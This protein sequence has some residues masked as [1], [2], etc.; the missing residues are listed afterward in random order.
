[1]QALGNMR[2]S[3]TTRVLIVIL[4]LG[5][6]MFGFG[7]DKNIIKVHFIESGKPEPFAVSDMPLEQLPDTFEIDTTMHL[8]DDD[9]Q[10]M[11]AEPAQ[12]EVF[13]KK[14]SLKLFLKK[15]EIVSIDPKDILYSLPTI[16]NDLA[17]VEDSET[18]ENIIVFREDDWRQF[19][20]LSIKYEQEIQKELRG[21]AEIYENQKLEGVGFKEIYL[22]KIIT[23]PLHDINLK[24]E[25]LEKYFDIKHQYSGVAFNNA[26]ATIVGGFAFSTTSGWELWGQVNANNIIQFINITQT[27]DSDVN[28]F[29]TKIDI[30][31]TENKMYAV[32]WARMFWAGHNK[33]A[34]SKYTK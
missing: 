33:H 16:S 25:V 6:P 23:T 22:R 29:A 19:E 14:G 2:N 4:V 28:L 31:L 34:F 13:R 21:V 20:L 26:A 30:F 17:D 7:K 24:L 10:V 15:S 32:D 18:F 1:M 9:W 27:E 8:G 5:Y 12:K 11:G 3:A